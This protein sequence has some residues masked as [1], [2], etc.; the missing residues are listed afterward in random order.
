MKEG[1]VRLGSWILGSL[2]ALVAA[3]GF[4]LPGGQR[5]AEGSQETA[6]P[7][8]G[9]PDLVGGLKATKGCLG[10]ETAGTTSGK[11]VI[12]AWFED[13]KAALAWYESKMHQEAMQRFF[14]EREQRKPLQQI[15]D[16]VGPIMAVASLTLAA[17]P[18]F[19]ESTL[20]ISQISIELYKPLPGGLSL[21]GSFAP[22]SLKVPNL[23]DYTPKKG[24]GD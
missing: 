21:G 19:Q 20:P 24:I 13:K 14:P 18:Q 4:F 11:M 1:R 17:T 16:D 23:K 5:S 9:F 8:Q 2:L 15:P 22:A 10:V 7:I 6:P 12:F 3:L